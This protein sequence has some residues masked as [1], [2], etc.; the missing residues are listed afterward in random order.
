MFSTLARLAT[1]AMLGAVLRFPPPFFYKVTFS[2][3]FKNLP[4][5]GA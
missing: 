4:S 5:S 3:K 2:P 1:N